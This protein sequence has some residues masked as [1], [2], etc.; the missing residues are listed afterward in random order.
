MKRYLRVLRERLADERGEIR[1]LFLK[2]GLAAIFVALIIVQVGPILSNQ[3]DIRGITSDAADI[4]INKY[5]VS[6]GNMDEVRQ[7]VETALAERGARL[8][9]E[10]AAYEGESGNKVLSFTAR[11]IARTWLFYHIDYLAPYT[12]SMSSVKK[13]IYD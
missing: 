3:I 1:G 8:V 9:G 13:N 12:E 5:R 10:I 4:G 7:S 2:M 6:K 11:K